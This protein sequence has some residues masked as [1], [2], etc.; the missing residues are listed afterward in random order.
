MIY[1]PKPTPG[2]RVAVLS[3]AAGLPAVFPHVFELG[4]TRLRSELGLVPVEYPTT[5]VLGAPAKERARDIHKAFTDPD[6]TAVLASIGGEDQIIVTPHLDRELLAAHPKPFFGY[7]DNTNLHNV[8]WNAGVVSYYGGSV[9]VHLGR[10]GATNPETMSS[11]RAALFTDGW[12]RLAPAKWW[13]DESIDWRN[14]DMLAKAPP[15]YDGEGWTWHNA[16]RVVEGRSWGGCIE[17]LSWIL[18][19]GLDIREPDAYAGCV[20]IIESS[21]EMPPAVEVH[22]ILRHMGERGLLA[23]FPAVM[24]GRPKAWEHGHETTPEQKRSY[25]ADQRDAVLRTLDRYA[26]EA[27]VVFDVD[28]GHT[29]PQLI[30]PYGGHV[31]IDGHARTVD[32]RY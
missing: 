7:S 23:Q 31:R 21:E 12:Q 15:M 14:P 4:L 17:V 30:V 28:F 16:D 24:V 18:Q 10:S 29:D 11:L 25:A 19:V 22:R 27:M 9:M 2:D 1:A 6:I 8:L 13:T 5:R 32:V 26:S 20:L 3:P